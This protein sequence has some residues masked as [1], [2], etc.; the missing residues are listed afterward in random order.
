MRV[1]RRDHS[2][3]RQYKKG[4]KKKRKEKSRKT[5]IETEKKE[6]NKETRDGPS[7]RCFHSLLLHFS[8]NILPDIGSTKLLK[9]N[10]GILP[11]TD[12]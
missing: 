5:K 2:D 12:S 10:S 11:E 7:F 8:Q 1:D 4:T 6:Q 9:P 3:Q